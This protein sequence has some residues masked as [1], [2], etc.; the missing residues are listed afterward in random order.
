[1]GKY[2]GEY[3]PVGHFGCLQYGLSLRS[4]WSNRWVLLSPELCL[5]FIFHIRVGIYFKL[6]LNRMGRDVFSNSHTAVL[7]DEC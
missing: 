5:G 6:A 1:M 2:Y 3:C 4:S 7:A